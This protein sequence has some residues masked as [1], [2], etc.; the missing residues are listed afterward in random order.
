MR[1]NYRAVKSQGEIVLFLCGNHGVAKGMVLT[2]LSVAKHTARPVKM[3]IG[4]MDLSDVDE[5]YIPVTDEDAELVRRA[6]LRGNPESTVRILDFGDAFRRELGGSKNMDTA[7]TPYA[8]IRL[9]ADGVEE[10]GD[11]VLYLD[12]DVLFLGDAG[13]LYDV[14]IEGYELGGCLDYFGRIFINPR[15]MNSGVMLWNMKELRATGALKRARRMCNDKKMLLMDQTAINKCVKRKLY[16]PRRFNEQ[17]DMLPDTLVRHFS[18]TIKWLPY[19]HTETVKPWQF[20]E[21]RQRL[22]ITAFDDVFEEYALLTDKKEI[23]Q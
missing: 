8:M 13:E 20:N 3:F 4:T 22:G 5:R 17:H 14:D 7:Y 21:V 12:C 10:L 9:F 19:F 1:Y 6:L 11:K 2:A 18:M 16:L 23:T 15:Y